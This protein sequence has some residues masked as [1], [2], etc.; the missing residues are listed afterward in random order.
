MSDEW[1][2]KTVERIKESDKTQQE[3]QS[4]LLHRSQIGQHQH[5]LFA[6]LQT[7]LK[8]TINKLNERL[9]K[10][11]DVLRSSRGMTRLKS[12]AQTNSS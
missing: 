10:R 9:L 5:K 11:S 6:D 3:Q 8:E 12:M 1:I 7:I 4:Y 2:N